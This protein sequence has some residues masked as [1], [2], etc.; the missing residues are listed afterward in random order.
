MN[1]WPGFNLL[2]LFPAL[3]LV[4]GVLAPL[5]A[6]A[7]VVESCVGVN[8]TV[9]FSFSGQAQTFRPPLNAK[10]L[11][12]EIAGAQGG[13]NGGG[14]GQVS[15]QLIEVPSLMYIFVGGAG[16]TGGGMAGGFNGGGT[17][18]S[19]SNFEG[20]GGGA[21][22]IRIGLDPSTRI[23]VAGGGGGR[24][25]GTGSGGGTGGGL[26]AGD[27][28][29]AQGFGGVG[30]SQDSA[31]T[32]GAANGTGTGGS[33]GNLGIG[34]TGGSSTLFGGG[35]GGG[36]YF[37]GGGGGSD[38]DSCCSDAGGGGGGSSF[39][40]ATLVTNVVHTSGLWPGAGRAII[41]YQL[42][43]L[44]S[45]ISSQVSGNQVSFHIEFNEAV[46][47]FE[48]SDVVINHSAR[49]C[50]SSSLTGSGASYELLI[51]GCEDGELS[52]LVQANSVSSSEVTG[53]VE[54]FASSKVLIDTVGPSASFGAPNSTQTLLEFSEP[55]QAL[56]LSAFEFTATDPS[57]SLSQLIEL[58]PKR[59]QLATA[60]CDLSDF[61][62]SLLALS[63][64]DQTGNS[65]PATTLTINF[66]AD[67]PEPQATDISDESGSETE[68][69]ENQ[70]SEAESVG[71]P[72][73]DLE[74]EVADEPDLHITPPASESL[75]RD[76]P[77]DMGE[78]NQ[79]PDSF[80]QPALQEII[81]PVPPASGGNDPIE[82]V[83]NAQKPND[84][85]ALGPEPLKTRDLFDS[86]PDERVVG[87]DGFAS[88]PASSLPQASQ[89][90][91]IPA[92]EFQTGLGPNGWFIGIFSMGIFAL[93]S[94]LIIARRG[95]P[96]IL[97]S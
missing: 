47:G 52:I 45:E 97:S 38:T 94:G 17:A 16:A 71:D 60:G 66:M 58:S 41:R 88:P 89:T 12:F 25:A 18:G 63:V 69:D 37:G 15:G 4:F 68:S 42:A 80:E 29:T 90:V 43:P 81:R 1:K 5:P 2:K 30:G 40:D 54:E 79:G 31:G 95:I 72:I 13:R 84:D 48:L 11:S 70:D 64:L 74:Q 92:Q 61:T 73:E 19:G 50:D 65:G 24:G 91:I 21:T 22:D 82:P 3:A 27:G 76:D 86:D 87:A 35:G 93:I 56:E 14:G 6:A 23:A 36:G 46:S 49:I 77:A 7:N 20:S 28:K 85:P 10:N 26:I 51:A 39:T 83:R 78:P 9:T 57:C 96:G 55:I 8:C 33:A 59:W 53:P 75:I 44:V 67:I 34:G 62:L 32:G